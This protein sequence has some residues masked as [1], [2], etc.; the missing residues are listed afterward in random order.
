[1]NS[2]DLKQLLPVS[3]SYAE[4]KIQ[5]NRSQSLVLNDGTL[6]QNNLSATGGL[7]ARV[8]EKGAWGLASSPD[9]T[10]QSMQSI[11]NKASENAQYLSKRLKGNHVSLPSSPAHGEYLFYTKKELWTTARKIE[12]LNA[13]DA[14]IQSKYPDLSSRTVAMSSHE[15]EKYIVTTDN[16]VMKSMTPRI[17]LVV[18]FNIIHNAEPI[19]HYAIFDGF[20]QFEDNFEKPETLFSKIDKLY[21]QL[22]DKKAAVF[23]KPGTFECVLDSKLAGILAHE[24]IGHTTEAD[25]VLNGSIAGDY[26]NQQVA[27]PLVTLIDVANTWDNKMCPVPVF[28]DDEGT[29]AEDC[30]VI[31]DGYLRAFMHNKESAQRMGHKLTGNARAYSFSDEPLIRMRN[32]MIV[33]GK[34]KLQEMIA[35][36]ENGYYLIDPSNGQADSTSE[37]MFGITLGYEIIKGKLGKAIKET[38]ISGVAFDLLKTVT[39]ISDEMDWSCAGMCGKKQ[40]IP[41]GM[42]GPAIKCKVNIGGKQ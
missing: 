3:L 14:Y 27:N 9:I 39:M 6:I 41:V 42:G 15:M 19:Q 34:D 25:L 35:S 4:L 7:M 29:R 23:A 5:E 18:V 21:E 30:V 2:F 13:I 33:P 36:I 24:A 37:F 12:F 8:F 26:L 40:P 38:T 10:P 16:S 28:I 11:I 1:M 20:G 31:R 32:T 17:I 22:M